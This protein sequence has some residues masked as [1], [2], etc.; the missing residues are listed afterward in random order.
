MLMYLYTEGTCLQRETVLCD[1]VHIGV[2]LVLLT[3]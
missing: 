3:P 1:R 2:S